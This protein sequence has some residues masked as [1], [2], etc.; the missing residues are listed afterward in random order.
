VRLLLAA[1]L[2]AAPLR[3]EDDGFPPQAKLSTDSDRAAFRRWICAVA[4]RTERARDCAD[5]MN[6]AYR[7]A[8]KRHDQRW[9]DASGWTAGPDDPAG[10]VSVGYP[11]PVLG[12]RLHR[13]VGGPFE[14]AA[15]A[16][17]FSPYATSQA[18]REFNAR[19]LGAGLSGLQD[20][21]ALFFQHPWQGLPDHGMLYCRGL[22]VYHTGPTAAGPGKVKR[23]RLE[24]LLEHPDPRWRPVP[25]NPYFLGAY[26]WKI[27]E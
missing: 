14:P 6:I 2:L 17:Q 24:R 4:L 18:L 5:L 25:G 7:E 9:R 11:V 13:A 23:V 20:G 16:E 1:F 15:V 27:L 12:T 3:A 8:L 22:L 19:R 26:R 10:D 21:D